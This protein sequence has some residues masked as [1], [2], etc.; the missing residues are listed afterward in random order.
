[1]NKW[2]LLYKGD[3]TKNLNGAEIRYIKIAE[4][5]ALSGNEVT[6]AGG[7]GH[8]QGEVK[9]VSFNKT[10]S[11][12]K[13]FM[14]ADIIMIHGGGPF[15]LILSLISKIL[16]KRLLLDNYA[17]HWVELLT[18]SQKGSRRALLSIKIAFNLFRTLFGAIVCDTVI[19]ANKRQQDLYRGLAA[20]SGNL[21]LI[22]KIQ[23][24]SYGADPV[25]ETKTRSHLIHLSKNKINDSDI[26]IGWI[27]SLWDWFDYKPMVAAISTVASSNNDLKLVFFG[28]D[29]NKEKEV[30]QYIATM[31][32]NASENF[33]FLPW[34]DYESRL[35]VWSGL[36]AGIVWA[37]PSI[38]NDYAARTRNY[39]CISARLP[40]IQNWDDYWGPI[41]NEHNIGIT[42]TENALESAIA[43]FISNR[44]LITEYSKNI[45][46]L[47]DEYSWRSITANLLSLT[48]TA[49]TR[50]SYASIAYLIILG[51]L[52]LLNVLVNR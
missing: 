40:I 26:L 29:K 50:P 33:L 36:D 2:L 17:P 20:S 12:I 32:G 13:A 31:A 44:E 39:D 8:Q 41:I 1:M 27:G 21:H 30:K 25:I 46:T 3:F 52:L 34:I 45:A 4:Q 9:F 10:L 42:T 19:A 5:L 51:P 22:D 11:L 28:V 37:N 35:E 16:G 18:V 23:I 48:S 7:L 14:C 47:Y 49:K 15:T 38:E 24:L 43:D 6:I